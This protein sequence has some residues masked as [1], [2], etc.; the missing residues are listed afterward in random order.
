MERLIVFLFVGFVIASPCQEARAYPKQN[1]QNSHWYDI[2]TVDEAAENYWYDAESKSAALGGHLATIR[3]VTEQDWVFQNI[4]NVTN[5]NYWVGLNDAVTE[6]QL[7]WP[8]GE[9]PPYR[10]WLTGYKNTAGKD[11]VFIR[12]SDGYW[13]MGYKNDYMRGIVEWT[14]AAPE[15]LSSALFLAGGIVLAWRRFRRR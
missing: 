8:S 7:I 10:N 13:D 15:P 9:E 5:R 2:V 1:P 12:Q 14:A 4:I 6:G 3:T 11:Y